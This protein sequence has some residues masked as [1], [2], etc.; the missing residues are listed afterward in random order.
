MLKDNNGNINV[1]QLSLNE[2]MDIQTYDLGFIPKDGEMNTLDRNA[3][4][5]IWWDKSE[6]LNLL[7]SLIKVSDEGERLFVGRI[8]ILDFRGE[9]VSL[10]SVNHD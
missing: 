8:R 10:R 1:F 3:T 9:N 5:E 7:P 2:N 4:Y 6:S